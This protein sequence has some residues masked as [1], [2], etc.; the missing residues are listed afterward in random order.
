MKSFFKF[1]LASVVGFLITGIVLIFITMGIIGGLVAS[2]T[3]K[4]VT[5]K[6]KTILKIDFS[7]GVTERTSQNPLEDMNFQTLKTNTKIGLN[8]ILKNLK[9]AKNDDNIKGIY[10]NNTGIGAGLGT[11]EEIRNALIDFKTSGK[12]IISY[13]DVYTQ[14]AYYLSTVSDQIYL[15]PEGF[16]DFKGLSSQLLFFKDALDKIGIEP[17]IIRGKNNKFK[18]AVEPFMYNHISEANKL[19]TLTYMG[20]LWNHILKG[21]SE[22]RSISIE[23]LNLYADSML[24]NNATEA[25]KYKLIDDLKYYDEILTILKEKSETDENDDINFM[26]MSSYT[27]TPNTPTGKGLIKEKIAVVYANGEIN[28][29]SGSEKEIGSKGLSKAIR[30]ARLD[31]NIKAVVLRINSPGGS[32]LASEVIWREV[33]LTKKVKPLIVSMGNVAASGGYYIAAPADKI[34]A[35]P[36][37][38]TGSIGVFGILWNTQDI[39]KKIGINSDAVNTNAHSD[40]GNMSRSMTDAEYATIQNS[41]EDIYDVFLGHVAEGRKMK[42]ED[43]DKIGQGRVWSGENAKE[44]GLVDEFGG[45]VDAIEYAKEMA[46]LEDYRIVELPKQEDPIEALMKDLGGNVKAYVLQEELGTSFKYYDRL[47]QLTKLKGVQARIPFI[48]DIK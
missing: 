8:D 10:I 27:N 37:T 38:I 34:F 36:V 17:V 21:I 24:I 44:I 7:N 43:V 23:N 46:K 22:T 26:S 33:M 48:L 35:N 5:I 14:G 20:S 16:V 15:N 30:E 13:S 12:F 45:L 11:I 47:N 31:T 2:S 3:D 4:S 32:A 18:S 19:Q 9:K 39:M 6:E 1:T 40:L 42:K 41:V 25:V 29:G 28:M